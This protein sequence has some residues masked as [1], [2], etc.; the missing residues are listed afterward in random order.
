MEVRLAYGIE[1]IVLHLDDKLNIDIINP[2][3]SSPLKSPTENLRESLQTPYNLDPL[4]EWISPNESVGV[5][6]SDITRPVP[7][8]FILPIILDEISHI[9]TEN[10]TLFNSLGT[11]RPNT[12]KEL[13]EMLGS[14]ILE[15]FCH[16]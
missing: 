6:F 12:D 9:K 5:V 15:K 16:Y 11:H 4:S 1:G 13:R 14:E 10:I 8:K 2:H 3:Y 7:L